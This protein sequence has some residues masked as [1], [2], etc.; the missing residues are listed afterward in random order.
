MKISR[1]AKL[2]AAVLPLAFTATSLVTAPA[3]TA[4]ETGA[5]A[6]QHPS[7]SNKDS[8]TGTIGD[9]INVGRIRTGPNEGCDVRHALF[10][11]VTLYYHCFVLN[12]A[13]NTWTHVRV[14]GTDINGWIWDYNLNNGGSTKLC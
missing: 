9:H 11:D 2:A 3:A 8:G 13:G 5:N 1:R 6:C 14:K 7:W 10:D 12:S 4:G